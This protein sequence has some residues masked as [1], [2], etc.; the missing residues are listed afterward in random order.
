MMVDAIG[1]IENPAYHSI[2]VLARI[3]VVMRLDEREY[4]RCIT[5]EHH[6]E[7]RIPLE[8]LGR[9]SFIYPVRY[10]RRPDWRLFQV[11]ESYLPSLPIAVNI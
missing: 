8:Y 3:E 4:M 5:P 2:A 10:K 9:E 11:R 6:H 1:F 7:M